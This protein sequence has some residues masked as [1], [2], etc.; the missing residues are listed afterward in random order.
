MRPACCWRN[1]C[2]WTIPAL[3]VRFQRTIHKSC[4]VRLLGLHACSAV[5]TV[6][7]KG[8]P[9]LAHR[10]ARHLV[11]ICLHFWLCDA[12]DEL[13]S[14]HLFLTTKLSRRVLCVS[15]SFYRWAINPPTNSPK[16]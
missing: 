10:S 11:D 4:D 8:G 13:M 2:R 3:L 12:H 7:L 14:G 15:D 1:S 16:G 5:S 9:R 6:F